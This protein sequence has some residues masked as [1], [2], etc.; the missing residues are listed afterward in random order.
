MFITKKAIIEA[1]TEV[2]SVPR[3]RNRSSKMVT[4]RHPRGLIGN[5]LHAAGMSP[6]E[7]RFCR[8]TAS[9]IVS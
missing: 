8:A 1:A 2:V 9:T 3:R 7:I 6:R 5:A 4:Y